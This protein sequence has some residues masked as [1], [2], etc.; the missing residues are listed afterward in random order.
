MPLTRVRR[1]GF[2]GQHLIVVPAPVR[3]AAA[4]HPILKGL[5]VTDAGYFPSAEGHRVERPQGASTH[6]IILCLQG[7]GWVRSGGKTTPVQAGEIIWLPA[8]APHAY[9]A[10]DTEPWKILWAHFLGAEVPAWQAELGWAARNPF[11]QFHFGPERL[12]TLGLDK[13]YAILESGYSIPHLLSAST[14]LRSVF[15]AALELMNSAGAARTA[16]ERTAAVREEISAA[17]ARPYRLEQLATAAGLSVPHFCLLFRRQTGYA[18]IDF[19]IRQRIRTACRLL[20]MTQAAVAAIASEA[21]F[22]DPYYFSRCF[23]RV[24]GQSPRAYRQRVKG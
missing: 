18:P 8:N 14:A 13:V 1:E 12:S 20:D 3:K 15:C 9:G 11:G 10:S 2:T 16:D 19:V 21:G 5:V 22:A 4:Q 7:S 17:P 23:H 24:M 6:L